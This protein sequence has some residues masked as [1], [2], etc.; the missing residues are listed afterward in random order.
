MKKLAI[1][2]TTFPADPCR[3]GAR[4]PASMRFTNASASRLSRSAAL[5]AGRRLIA[6]LLTA[7]GA[8]KEAYGALRSSASGLV[9]PGIAA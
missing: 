1:A 9:S 6:D 5:W 3:E 7:L 2:A 8:R 4:Y